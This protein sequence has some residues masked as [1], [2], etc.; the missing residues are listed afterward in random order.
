MLLN[1]PQ[2]ASTHLF[3]RA[4]SSETTL[5][6][7]LEDPSDALATV[8]LSRIYS[9]IELTFEEVCQQL[10][11][12]TCTTLPLRCWQRGGMSYYAALQN[13]S[14]EDDSRE[15]AE[16]PVDVDKASEQPQPRQNGAAEP[17]A[18]RSYAAAAGASVAAAAASKAA[19]ED[20][21]DADTAQPPPNTLMQNALIW[22]DLE[23]TG[24]DLHG[25]DT[26]I[27]IAVIV[28]DSHMR[29]EIIV[30]LDTPWSH[31][32]HAWT[33]HHACSSLL[34]PPCG[35]QLPF[36][37]AWHSRR[38]RGCRAAANHAGWQLHR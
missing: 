37:G 36:S 27:E 4:R 16:K 1:H 22:I 29:E 30:R 31:V 11:K 35:L 24:L 28:T 25:R 23:M 34:Q 7:N 26:I 20:A 21:A 9:G 14:L 3:R 18:S 12:R 5:H 13:L 6:L 15:V 32:V 10:V 17:A 2:P 33:A 38:R 8:S 19:R